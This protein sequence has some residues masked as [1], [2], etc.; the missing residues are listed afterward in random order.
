MAS[1]ILFAKEMKYLG[2]LIILG[3]ILLLAGVLIIGFSVEIC[4]RL[5]RQV[6]R[7]M[8]PSLL[9]TSNFHEVKHWIEPGDQQI[10]DNKINYKMVY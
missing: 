5:R 4:L 1:W 8:D 10:Q 3:P 2:P 9:K 7:V 6:K